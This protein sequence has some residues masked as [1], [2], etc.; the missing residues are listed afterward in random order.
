MYCILVKG[1]AQFHRY[2]ML[3]PGSPVNIVCTTSYLQRRRRVFS[4]RLHERMLWQRRWTFCDA[5]RLLLLLPML[6]LILPSYRHGMTNQLIDRSLAV[7]DDLF[8]A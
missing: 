8:M 3:G 2:N 5:F 1:S 4:L 7:H 6:V